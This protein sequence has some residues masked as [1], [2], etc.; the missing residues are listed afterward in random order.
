[1]ANKDTFLPLGGGAQG[2]ERVFVPK[3]TLVMIN[4]HCLHR[5][6]DVFGSDANEFK[7]ERWASM[8]TSMPWSYLPF[9]GGPRIC[10]G[11]RSLKLLPGRSLLT[12]TEQFAVAEVSYT[13]IRLLQAFP[14]LESRDPR[15][16]RESIGIS[17]SNGNGARVAFRTGRD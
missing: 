6:E 2:N 4:T 15:P 13:L 7:P 10:L 1:M 14:F 9:G 5:R 17:S 16:W 3:G 8:K 11:R 12:L